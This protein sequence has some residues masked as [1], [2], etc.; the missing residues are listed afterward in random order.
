[1]RHDRRMGHSGH[2]GLRAVHTFAPKSISAW[3][4]SKTSF[5][6][7]MTSDR[8]Q[9]CR[10][11]AWLLASPVATNTRKRTRATLVSRIAARCRNAKLRMAPAVYAPMPLKE[12]SVC[13]SDEHRFESRGDQRA[14]RSPLPFLDRVDGSRVGEQR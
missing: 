11:I 10:R 6:G 9:R 13:S 8:A 4:K 2:W 12:S 1:M 7:T 5:R 14:R 3:L